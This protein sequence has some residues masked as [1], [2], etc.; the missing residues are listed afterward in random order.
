M[1]LRSGMSEQMCAPGMV[2]TVI[3][4]E[5]VQWARWLVGAAWLG[6]LIA[7][8]ADLFAMQQP[9]IRLLAVLIGLVAFAALYLWLLYGD[10]RRTPTHAWMR[11]WIAFGLLVLAALAYNL[12]YGAA[13]LSL[14]IFVNVAASRTPP[15]LAMGLIV[16][17]T[18]VA[19]VLAGL[20]GWSARDIGGFAVQAVLIGFSMI[21]V[22]RMGRLNHELRVAREELTRRAVAEERLRFARDLHDSVTQELFSMTLHAR[23]TVKQMERAETPADDPVYQQVRILSDL[24]QAALAEMRML[25]FELRPS[26][27]AEEGLVG[28]V[29]KLA[30]SVSAREDLT[31]EVDAPDDRLP[32]ESA[33]EEH[34]YRLIQE[35]LNNVLKHAGAR[36]AVVSIGAADD[37]ERL[38]VEIRDD[39]TGFNPAVAHPGHMGLQTM[40]ARADE[41]G[42]T[43]AIESAPG[44]GTTV[45]VTVPLI[46]TAS[47]RSRPQPTKHPLPA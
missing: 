23:T 6:V 5:R 43:Y 19:V 12:I 29:R 47:A 28:A 11:W 25:I 26:A 40:A 39:G 34:L 24:A 37:G 9:T 44:N 8:I 33:T 1:R 15:R 35:A 30:A 42:G 41:L 38:V 46:H 32:L 2:D 16:V 14:F 27:L 3:T 4:D 13:W 45:R 18:L 17:I 31:I 7:P 21:G 22:F 36:R 10:Q 20:A